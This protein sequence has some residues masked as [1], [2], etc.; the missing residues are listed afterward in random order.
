MDYAVCVGICIAIT[1]GLGA[2]LI[3]EASCA[4]LVAAEAN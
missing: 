2:L 3:C 1:E 4:A